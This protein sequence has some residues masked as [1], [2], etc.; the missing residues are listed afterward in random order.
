M[1][2]LAHAQGFYG[3]VWSD[4]GNNY[5]ELMKT[6]RKVAN[7]IE[8]YPWSYFDQTANALG[9]T[10]LD[11]MAGDALAGLSGYVRSSG[12]HQPATQSVAL[13]M[14]KNE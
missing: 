8:K 1:V 11:F 9:S 6:A 13:I 12:A 2:E 5:K 3:A 4:T 7:N 14:Q 10:V